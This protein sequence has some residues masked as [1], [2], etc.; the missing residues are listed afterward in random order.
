MA[1]T[2]TQYVGLRFKSGHAWA[3]IEHV[4]R[5]IVTSKIVL[6]FSYYI[7][8]DYMHVIT[9]VMIICMSVTVIIRAVMLL[10]QISYVVRSDNSNCL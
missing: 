3:H 4:H 9:L 8:N 7:C 6:I 10:V 1:L 5:Q 2:L